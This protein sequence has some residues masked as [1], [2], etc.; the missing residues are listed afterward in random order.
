MWHT[1][2]ISLGMSIVYKKRC[3][4]KTSLYQTIQ[5]HFN[6]T[7]DML[8]GQ[9]KCIPEF[10]KKEVEKYLQ[11]GIFAYGFCRVSCPSCKI[12]KLVAF[13]CKSRML[14][15]S[16]S[17]RRMSESSAFLM[18]N[19][20]PYVGVRQWVVSFPFGLRFLMAREPKVLIRVKKIFI[21]EV[22]KFYTGQA[23]KH[24]IE[25][26]LVGHITVLQRFGS[27]LNLNPH[28]HT[29][30]LDGVY[31]RDFSN[32]LVF[33][34]L[35][36]PCNETIL[37]IC[38][39]VGD[40][41]IK[42]LKKYTVKEDEYEEISAHE[43]ALLASM[44]SRVAWGEKVGQSLEREMSTSPEIVKSSRC[45]K[46]NGISIHADRSHSAANRQGIELLLRYIM[47]PNIPQS[48][49]KVDGS[50]KVVLKLKKK[51]NDGT[52]KLKFD[53]VEFIGRVVAM[54]P[55]PRKNLLTYGGVLAPNFKDRSQIIPGKQKSDSKP[56]KCY[57]YP[58]HELLKRVFKIDVL[59]CDECNGKMK[60]I[61]VIIEKKAIE[62]ILNHLGID[63]DPPAITNFMTDF[64][65]EY[66]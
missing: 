27:S 3:P 61:A 45:V 26:P 30:F 25:K 28:F 23:L 58:W 53:P 46:V 50:G 42:W 14:C 36:A 22:Q 34:P 18:D 10:I 40:R 29:V 49:L 19:V 62:K 15:P 12:D 13:S 51:F 11:C 54:V 5:R 31:H 52:T 35:A 6:Q 2:R 24:G 4:E 63:S 64:Q 33:V 65:I 32:K 1:H 37:G 41:V 59:V 20:I 48:R 39:R 8:E 66:D 60:F 55:P 7:V 17:G 16:C 44:T 9:G 38:K 47:R 56:K 43:Q 57:W 21:S